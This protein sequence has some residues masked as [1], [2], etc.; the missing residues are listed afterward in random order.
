MAFATNVVPENLQWWGLGREIV[1]NG[2]IAQPVITI[3]LDK[4]QPDDKPTMIVDKGVRGSMATDFGDIQGVE[5]A[6]FP[7][8]GDVYIDSIGHLIYN[9]CG[10]Y[11]SAGSTPTSATTVPLATAVG[12]TSF[13]VTAIGTIV[14]GSV[15][16]YGN[17]TLGTA[18]TEN[19]IVSAVAGSL[20]TFA[21]TPLRFAH[22]TNAAVALVTAPFIHTFSLLNGGL[23]GN[24]QPPSH[25]ITYH[26]NLAGTFLARQYAY[27]CS[28]GMDFKLNSEQLFQHDTKGTSVLGVIAAAAPA[29]TQTGAPAIAD[30]NF[31]VGIGGPA[32]GGTLVN[33]IEE[34][35]VNIARILKPQFTLQG[36]Q[37]PFVI[38]RCGFSVTGK[39]TFMAQDESPLLALLANTQQQL[40]IAMTQG[41]GP[42]QTGIV[43]NFQV[44]AYEAAT[45][46]AADTLMYD[47]NFRALANSTNAGASGGLSPMSIVL[48]NAISTY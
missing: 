2:T 11:Q 1:A 3:P 20:V 14:V 19:L 6:D 30:W 48:T 39:L 34:A 29:N 5:I 18:P 41:A 15:L 46:G 10:D 22:G 32:T 37:A 33:N 35:D 38:A 28:S 45:I 8:S 7:L 42:A 13:T 12:A 4:G 44:A 47:V 16:Q 9:T 26:N 21:T 40:Q 24:G 25:T 17:A 36:T 31:K 23:G 43:F 27:W